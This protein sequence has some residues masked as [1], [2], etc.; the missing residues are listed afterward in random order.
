[1][2]TF[3]M[4]S[5]PQANAMLMTGR[6]IRIF[7]ADGKPSGILTAEIMNWTGK[8]VVC[9]RTDLQRLADRPECRR[10]GAYILAGPDP[11]DPYGERAYIGES[12]NVF[13]RLK[14]HAADASKEFWT[15]CALIISK[16]ENLTKAHVKYLESRLVGLAHEASRCVL[17]NGNDPSSPSLPE[18]DIADMEFFLSQL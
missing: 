10:S 2:R 16:D 11:D 8:V 6:T 5:S 18:S 17:E 9:P 12:D 4:C 13:A 7:L 14:Q 1:M 15:R 3:E